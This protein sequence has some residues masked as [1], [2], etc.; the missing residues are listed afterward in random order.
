MTPLADWNSP[1]AKSVAIAIREAGLQEQTRQALSNVSLRLAGELQAFGSMAELAAEVVRLQPDILLLG[2]QG[3]PGDSGEVVRQIRSL[4]TAPR[5]VAVSDSPNSDL[6]LEVMRAGASEFL[7]PPFDG[8]F[9]DSLLRVAA[10]CPAD[11]LSRTGGRVFGFV[12]AKGGCGATTLACHTAASLR[13]QTGKHVLLADLDL[14]SGNIGYLMHAETRYS[15]VDALE[16]LNRLDLTLWR[17]LATPTT[18]GVDMLG[19]P[20]EPMEFGAQAL[21]LTSLLHFWR[22]QYDFTVVDLGHGLTP[23]LCQLRDVFDSLVLVTTDE[24]AALRQARQTLVT[25]GKLNI[26]VNRLRLVINRMPRRATVQAPEL[27]RILAFPI[28]ATIPNHYQ[29]LAEAYAEARLV[30]S[31]SPLGIP[32]SAFS[33]KL[34]GIP[35]QTKDSRKSRRLGIFG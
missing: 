4:E 5:V 11:R 1:G 32:L 7:Y 24:L 17:A 2:L 26:G 20:P 25:L 27:E 31:A 15:L 34:A 13:K 16:N 18:V 35:E 19:A 9:A 22:L 29:Q 14:C 12:S 3:L 8:Q 28:Y 23:A 33:A 21:A 10:D 6:I 30:D